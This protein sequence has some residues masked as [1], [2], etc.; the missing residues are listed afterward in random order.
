MNAI[1][2]LFGLSNT[3]A[4][5]QGNSN[6]RGCEK[7]TQRLVFPLSCED[8]SKNV[9]T[10]GIISGMD[11]GY[12]TLRDP[13]CRVKDGVDFW[14]GWLTPEQVKTLRGDGAVRAIISNIKAESDSLTRA[15]LKAPSGQ[16]KAPDTSKNNRRIANMPNTRPN[17]NIL[18]NLLSQK[19]GSYI[20]KRAPMVVIQQFIDDPTLNFLSTAPEKNILPIFSYFQPAG[21]DVV[22][23]ILEPSLPAYLPEIEWTRTLSRNDDYKSSELDPE[24]D[25][26]LLGLCTVDRIGGEQFGVAKKVTFALY[27]CGPDLDSVMSTM[28]QI[29]DAI[30]LW[31]TPAKNGFV[32]N[33][34]MRFKPEETEETEFADV[35]GERISG[36][37]TDGVIFVASAGGGLANTDETRVTAY[38]GRLS[39]RL[40]IITVGFVSPLDGA[41][42]GPQGSEVTVF[43]PDFGRCLH[44]DINS[45]YFGGP[46]IAVATV[47]GL[48]AYFLSLPDLVPRF[49]PPG[50]DRSRNMI[51]YLQ[52]LSHARFEGSQQA[53]VWN[54][55]DNGESAPS[56]DPFY[57]DYD[58]D[59]YAQ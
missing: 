46:G 43:A 36:L 17:F 52:E 31:Q 4:H 13:A 58:D 26:R 29:R 48:V 24:G 39:T 45:D 8:V 5:L 16:I 11:P 35:M 44:Y 47:T 56:Q 20:D 12:K 57:D 18:N 3:F 30:R 15:N 28:A 19:K 53:A 54:G 38:P 9:V 1:K 25:D 34:R 40:P 41:S 42:V 32:M 59:W 49:G 55:R 7:A 33:A 10:E 6:A 27:E 2:F 23:I 22:V 50:V 37:I 21:E 14:L 51:S